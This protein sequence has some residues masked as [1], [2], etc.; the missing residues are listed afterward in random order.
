MAKKKADEKLGELNSPEVNFYN[1]IP[2]QRGKIEIEETGEKEK[3]V[4]GIIEAEKLQKSGWQQ[5]ACYPTSDDP[6]GD[7]TYKFRKE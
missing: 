3:T 6:F 4:I 1:P 2:S 5:I 7:K